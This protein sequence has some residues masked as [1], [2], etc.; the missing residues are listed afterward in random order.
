MDITL[1]NMTN[2]DG[3]TDPGWD[4]LNAVVDH[5]GAAGMSSDESEDDEM[6]RKVYV[7]NKAIWRDKRVTTSLRLVDGDHN[8]TN[9]FGNRKS[10][11]PARTR[12]VRHRARGSAREAPPGL[13]INFYDSNWYAGLTNRERNELIALPEFQLPE[14]EN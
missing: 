9:A 6:G 12:V 7:V 11:N 3:S 14:V 13:P 2:P 4:A 5:L 8:T 10:G 1:G